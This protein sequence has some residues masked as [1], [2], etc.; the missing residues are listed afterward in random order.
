[1]RT[2]QNH[3]NNMLARGVVTSSKADGKMQNLQVGLLAG[4]TKDNI[5]HFEPYGFTSN[6]P[7]GSEV[8]TVFIE[9][10]RSHGVVI[11]AAD[12]RVRIK[13][14]GKGFIGLGLEGG[15]Q[16]VIDP[17][18]TM[19]ITATALHIAATT[20]TSSGEW[21]HTGEFKA[22]GISLPH[23]IHTDPQGG[24]TGQPV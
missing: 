4:E 8:M 20:I 23:H 15:P 16:L 3:I 13:N 9:G 10:D 6:P 24:N 21:T 12:R 18:G 14:L 22:D 11:C 19:I 7:D 1:M 5:E 2:P 17:A